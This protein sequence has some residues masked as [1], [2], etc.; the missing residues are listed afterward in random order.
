[1]PVVSDRTRLPLRG[2]GGRDRRQR[3]RAEFPLQ[4]G[5]SSGGDLARHRAGRA[6]FPEQVPRGRPAEPAEIGEGILFLSTVRTRFLA[7]AILDV[8]GGWPAGAPLPA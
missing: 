5:L 1:M 2:P 3:R 8:S 6:H 4:Q 7:G